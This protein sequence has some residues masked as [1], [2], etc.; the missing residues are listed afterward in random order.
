[1]KTDVR[2]KTLCNEFPGL[3]EAE[4]DYILGISQILAYSV[5]GK[6]VKPLPV[7]E[8]REVSKNHSTFVQYKEYKL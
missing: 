7:A 1:M 8:M 3:N 6:G 4:K 2:L 5:L